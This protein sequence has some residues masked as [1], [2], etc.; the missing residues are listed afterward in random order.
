MFSLLHILLYYCQNYF[1]TNS[2]II[3]FLNW[4]ILSAFPAPPLHPPLTHP[5]LAISVLPAVSQHDSSFNSGCI[6]VTSYLCH[7]CVLGRFSCIWLFATPWTI[8]YQASLSLRFS[9]QEYWNGLPFAPPEDLPDP[10]IEPVSPAA[11]SLRIDSLLL[12][13]RGSPFVP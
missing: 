13:H 1:Q 6:L 10:G 9:R 4:F 12:S 11:P 5:A 7:M 2:L 8:A 3:S